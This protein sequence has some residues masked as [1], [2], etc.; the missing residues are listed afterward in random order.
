MS[1]SLLPVLVEVPEGW[2][3]FGQK[4]FFSGGDGLPRS[5]N[6]PNRDYEQL[7]GRYTPLSLTTAFRDQSANL[8]GI[9]DLD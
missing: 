9:I 8:L 4:P 7:T 6:S 1:D 5:A 3:R 2:D